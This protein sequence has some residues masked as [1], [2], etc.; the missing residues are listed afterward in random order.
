M[1]SRLQVRKN[2]C[3]SAE[4][5]DSAEIFLKSKDNVSRIIRLLKKFLCNLVFYLFKLDVCCRPY[6]VEVQMARFKLWKFCCEL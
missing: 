3:E 6:T 1:S 2:W 5:D 4:S